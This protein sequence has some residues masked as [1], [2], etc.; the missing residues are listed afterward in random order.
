VLRGNGFTIA[1]EDELERTGKWL[2]VRRTLE[3]GALGINLVE[4]PPGE[5]IP[6]HDETDR[7][8]EEVFYVVSG[9]PS[10]VIE[11]EQ[12]PAPAGTFARLDPHLRRTVR[13]T[14]REPAR[15]LIVSA[16]RTSGFEPLEW[17]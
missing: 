7:D 9:E 3:C 11:D 4:I 15:V 16:P 10:L 5:D 6:E 12:H 2:L 1:T 17:A 13:N 14:G 8:Q